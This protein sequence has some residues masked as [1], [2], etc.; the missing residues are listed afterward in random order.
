M[1]KD[2]YE[3]QMSAVIGKQLSQLEE[4]PFIKDLHPFEYDKLRRMLIDGN[5][6]SYL[7]G[8]KKGM[9]ESDSADNAEH[10]TVPSTVSGR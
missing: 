1:A 3:R 6:E 8:R 7:I 2:T 5:W 10:R 4:L 9:K